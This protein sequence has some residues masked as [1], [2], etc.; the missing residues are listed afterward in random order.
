MLNRLLITSMC[1]FDEGRVTKG[2]LDETRWCSDESEVE[3]FNP[4]GFGDQRLSWTGET[5][6]RE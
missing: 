3:S 5:E 4:S 2:L 1:C 6:S